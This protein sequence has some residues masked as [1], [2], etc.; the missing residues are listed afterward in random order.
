M[1][2]DWVLVSEGIPVYDLPERHF[3]YAV[4][5][6]AAPH[7]PIGISR[8]HGD[9]R[10][11]PDAAHSNKTSAS[12]F[13]ILKVDQTKCKDPVEIALIMATFILRMAVAWG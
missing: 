7:H 13:T 8:A 6:H 3:S 4:A 1:K 11:R 2:L 9:P 10:R 12:F 5:N